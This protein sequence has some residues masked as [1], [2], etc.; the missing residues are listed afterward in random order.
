MYRYTL[1]ACHITQYFVRSPLSV[2]PATHSCC[3]LAWSK[4][5]D[6]DMVSPQF[7]HVREFHWT[8]CPVGGTG[9]KWQ[10]AACTTA[11]FFGREWSKWLSPESSWR[12]GRWDVSSWVGG[13]AG[14]FY[15]NRPI[16][17][18]RSQRPPH[19]H[20]DIWQGFADSGFGSSAT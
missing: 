18:W 20:G 3:D 8:G 9:P 10:W 11:A 1:S 2:D 7:F 14:R 16:T 17:S 5:R 13:R 12:V 15:T 19:T 6:G 4:K